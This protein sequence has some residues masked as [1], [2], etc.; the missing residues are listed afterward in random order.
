MPQSK[1]DKAIHA[2]YGSRGKPTAKITKTEYNKLYPLLLGGLPDENDKK[3]LNNLGEKYGYEW[4]KS[5]IEF[6][7]NDANLWIGKL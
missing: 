7:D 4:K 6:L 1:R 5:K 2:K 3:F